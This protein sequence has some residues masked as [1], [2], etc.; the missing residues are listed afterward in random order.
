[1]ADVFQAFRVPHDRRNTARDLKRLKADRLVIYDEKRKRW[2][3]SAEGNERVK[4]I[5]DAVDLAAIQPELTRLP[6]VEFSH[7]LHTLLPSG[8]APPKWAA[9]IK[10]LHDR[11]PFER[12]VFCMTRFPRDPADRGFLDPVNEVIATARTAL[13]AHGLT[14][15]LAAD[16]QI[17]DDLLSN[18]AGYM[19]ACKYGV[20]LFENRRPEPEADLNKNMLIEV[21]AMLMTGRRCALLRDVNAPPMPTDLTAQIR[22]D[23]DYEDLAAVSVTLHHWAAEDLGLGR[24]PGCP[25]A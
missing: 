25:K 3:L 10:R 16:R 20:A 15:H 1:M 5:V 22:K 17:E 7:A 21:G 19:W 13:E 9:A 2:A 14:L 8:L 4:E 23:A 12:N 18:I 11:F 24:C 6:G